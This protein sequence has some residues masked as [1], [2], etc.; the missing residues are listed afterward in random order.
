MVHPPSQTNAEE[1]PGTDTE[2]LQT[3]R[4]FSEEP[5]AMVSIEDLETDDVVIAYVMQFSTVKSLT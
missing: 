1:Q 3:A 5:L 4:G 2:H